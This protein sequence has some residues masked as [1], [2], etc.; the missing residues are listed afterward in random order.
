MVRDTGERDRSDWPGEVFPEVRRY[1]CGPNGG[2][3]ASERELDRPWVSAIDYNERWS[4]TFET[5]SGQ[6]KS[7]RT[8][9]SLGALTA[10]FDPVSALDH[11]GFEAYR[12]GSTVELEE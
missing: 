6:K 3:P 4:A 2:V 11:I 8:H 9:L 5:S 12:T 7:L 1:P 10:R